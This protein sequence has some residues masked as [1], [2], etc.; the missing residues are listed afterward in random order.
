MCYLYRQYI[1]N[2]YIQLYSEFYSIYCNGMIHYRLVKYAMTAVMLVY[3]IF[4]KILIPNSTY[5]LAE[6]LWQ[7]LAASTKQMIEE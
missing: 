7:Q 2:F 4:N 6:I 1:S 3:K 5:D